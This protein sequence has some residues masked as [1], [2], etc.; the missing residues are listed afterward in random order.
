MRAVSE[1]HE[2]GIP[3]VADHIGGLFS[4]VLFETIKEA[5]NQPQETSE[6]L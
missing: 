3:L 2:L 6:D 4:L 5:L 1:M